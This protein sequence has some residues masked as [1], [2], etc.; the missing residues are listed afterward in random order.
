MAGNRI[1]VAVDFSRGSLQALS[2]ARAIARR[3]GARLT[4][5]HVRPFSDVRAA[6][7]EERGDLVRAGGRVLVRELAAHYA[8]RLGALARKAGGEQTLVL[9]GAPEVELSK[10]VRRGYDLL[11]LGRRGRNTVSTLFVGS[12]AERVLS[13]SRVPVLIVPGRGR[14]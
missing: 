4:L 3:T 7:A 1:M 5:A 2:A 11:V 10:A 9:R 8:R 14:A 13:R 6:V 12:T